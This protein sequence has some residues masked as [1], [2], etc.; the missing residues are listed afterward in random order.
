MIMFKENIFWVSSLPLIL[1]YIY[2][3]VLKVFFPQIRCQLKIIQRALLPYV[4]LLI[5][6]CTLVYGDGNITSSSCFIDV[7]VIVHCSVT[8]DEYEAELH[9]YFSDTSSW[10]YGSTNP[11]AK[12]GYKQSLVMPFRV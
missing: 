8:N 6:R 2:E 9:V 5:E 3:S 11:L 7:D 12:S 4:P 1:V 10:G